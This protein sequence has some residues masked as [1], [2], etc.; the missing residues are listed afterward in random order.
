MLRRETDKL[1]SF[2]FND[3]DPFELKKVI[4]IIW[5]SNS[6]EIEFKIHLEI[7]CI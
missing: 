5:K 2:V 6:F 4:K 3:D 7:N 1:G